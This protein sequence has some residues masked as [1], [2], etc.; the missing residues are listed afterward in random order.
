MERARKTAFVGIVFTVLP[1][2]CGC[3]V[4]SNPPSP[5]QPQNVAGLDPQALQLLRSKIAEVSGDP[6]S[7]RAHGMLG[8]AY[9]ANKMW[10]E[11]DA[12]FANAIELDGREPLWQ[13]HRAI[14]VQSWGDLALAL[15]LYADLASRMSDSAAFQHRFGDALLASGRADEAI[16]HFDSVIRLEPERPEG[17]VGRGGAYLNLKELEKAAADLERA[18]ELDGSYRSAHYLLGLTYR[19]L[20]RNEAAARELALGLD[21]KIRYL[22]DELNESRKALAVSYGTR[23]ERSLAL[24]KS[25]KNAKAVEILEELSRSHPEDVNALNNLATG[26]RRLGQDQ[27]ALGLLERVHRIDPTQF[28]TLINLAA[29]RLDVGDHRGALADAERAVLLAPDHRSTQMVLGQVLSRMGKLPEARD[30]LELSLGLGVTADGY[31][32]LGETCAAMQDF[33]KALECFGEAIRIDPSHLN[34]HINLCRLYLFQGQL[35]EAGKVLS[36]AKSLDPTHPQ[37]AAMAR[38]LD[39]RKRSVR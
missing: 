20:K 10:S 21:G 6:T 24:L 3:G 27:R 26:Y 13:L 34:A 5:V 29:V 28:A 33:T 12:S 22:P 14:A 32:L 31:N 39:Q 11:A 1:N 2:L 23:M 17:Y 25:G 7:A 37:L 36:Q 9:E 16:P 8:L 19:G 18:V 35:N 30:A 4:N 38:E 15:E